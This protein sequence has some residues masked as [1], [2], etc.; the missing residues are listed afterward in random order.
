MDLFIVFNYIIFIFFKLDLILMRAA[1]VLI[2]KIDFE[3]VRLRII[4]ISG[5]IKGA[6]K[7]ATKYLGDFVDYSNK[8]LN[9][10]TNDNNKNDEQEMKISE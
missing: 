3:K 7:R 4:G 9:E 10:K 8:I 2:N 5:T 6:E 1:L